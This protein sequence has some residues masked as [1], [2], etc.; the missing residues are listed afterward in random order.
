MHS[1][2]VEGAVVHDDLNE[3]RAIR[4]SHCVRDRQ[5]IPFL[6]KKRRKIMSYRPTQQKLSY[7]PALVQL[8]TVP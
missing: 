3:H 5:K 6:V 1:G 2:M 7:D 8:E 4:S